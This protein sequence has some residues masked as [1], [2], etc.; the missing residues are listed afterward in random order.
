MM[1]SLMTACMTLLITAAWAQDVAHEEL[2]R[3]SYQHN[4]SD[5]QSRE[6]AHK[7]QNEK[8][9]Q[10]GQGE[11]LV[12][13]SI[14]HRRNHC[15]ADTRGGVRLIRQ[16]SKADCRGNW[17]YDYMG[18]WVIEG[19]RAEFRIDRYSDYYGGMDDVLRCE[20]VDY[21]HTTCR[22]NL[23]NADVQLV[24]QLSRSDCRGNW[25]YNNNHIWVSNGC[26]ADFHVTRQYSQASPDEYITCASQDNRYRHCPADTRGQ[27]QLVE[28]LSRSDCRGNW[29]H[30]RNGIWV[31]NG[32]RARFTVTRGPRQQDWRPPNFGQA[33]RDTL[34][35][36]SK[37]NRREYCHAD[38][39]RGVELIDQMSRSSCDGHWGYDRGG[40][41]VT[42]GCQ[43]RFSLQRSGGPGHGY[44][45]GQGQRV[46][47]VKCESRNDRMETCPIGPHR[48][49]DMEKK[50]SR[51]HCDGYWGVKNNAIWVTRGCRAEFRVQ[52]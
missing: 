36:R 46:E 7:Y 5:N 10:Y 33:G 40:V 47:I 8:H 49:V 9:R 1:K 13:E 48:R 37:N 44:G 3:L 4:S 41:W 30:D 45:H 20:S 11:T 50:L 35:C 18:I 15:Y 28:Q 31:D 6:Q 51:S 21:R 43:A 23:R 14:D 52:R 32:C 26:R 19:C 25:G 29:G 24:H 42:D 34:V 38:T 17:G 16:I 27:A 39:S 12:C 22:H 2:D